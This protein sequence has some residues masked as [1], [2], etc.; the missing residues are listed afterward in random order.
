MLQTGPAQG[1]EGSAMPDTDFTD[2]TG[3]PTASHSR[4]R[5]DILEPGPALWPA[6]L[7]VVSLGF[8]LARQISPDVSPSPTALAYVPAAMAS[9]TAAIMAWQR[10]RQQATGWWLG[11]SA[12]FFLFFILT[13]QQ[14]LLATWGGLLGMDAVRMPWQPWFAARLL[15]ALGILSAYGAPKGLLPQAGAAKRW[16]V[17]KIACF[18][19]LASPFW[20]VHLRWSLYR[21]AANGLTVVDS[22]LLVA[23]GILLVMAFARTR[24]A[25]KSGGLFHRL[26]YTWLLALGWSAACRAFPFGGASTAN[27]VELLVVGVAGSIMCAQLVWVSGSSRARLETAVR[28][29]SAVHT[30][31]RHLAGAAPERI[32]QEFLASCAHALK[33]GRAVLLLTK[34]DEPAVEVAA[35]LPADSGKAK[36][37]DVL[38]LDSP[39]RSGFHTGPTAQAMRDKRTL[40]VDGIRSDVSFVDWRELAGGQGY[41][42]SVPLV[43]GGHCAGALVLWFPEE[44]WK[45]WECGP[46]AEEIVE[47]AVPAIIRMQKMH[48]PAKPEDSAQNAKAA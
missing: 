29:M 4:G 31:L 18:S 12:S 26:L 14:V 44:A 27:W 47:A 11:A 1:H 33:P 13:V 41:Q 17:A 30:V 9:L 2:I 35:V 21:P 5:T 22:L 24:Q 45:P 32:P 34:Q 43:S 23:S 42:V 20:A 16:A 15:L 48:P 40:V 19:L 7:V 8:F 36:V 38:S 10:F 28:R 6:L 3:L 46:L 37:G 39:R 25:L